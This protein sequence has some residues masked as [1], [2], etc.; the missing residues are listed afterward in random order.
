[1]TTDAPRSAKQISLDRLAA[2][3]LEHADDPACICPT[4]DC[5]VH[6]DWYWRD[7]RIVDADADV[8]MTPLSDEEKVRARVIR[9]AHSIPIKVA[10]P[11]VPNVEWSHTNLAGGVTTF[12]TVEVA[13]VWVWAYHDYTPG[14]HDH[15]TDGG[16]THDAP[17]VV[18]WRYPD[19][20]IDCATCGDRLAVRGEWD[21]QPELRTIIGLIR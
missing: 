9:A 3:D 13:G 14:P 12:R 2:H 20:T 17:W 18:I 15:Y 10:P 6:D 8:D 16:C 5:P 1:M 11:A 4:A 7:R 21:A 19:G